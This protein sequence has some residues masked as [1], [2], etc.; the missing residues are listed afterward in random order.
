MAPRALGDEGEGGQKIKRE[1]WLL[2]ASNMTP[3]L[4]KASSSHSRTQSSLRPG[5][6][7]SRW[8]YPSG[9]ALGLPSPLCKSVS[10]EV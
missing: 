4:G 6:G 2:E 5:G 9:A 10:R 7:S 3:E 1:G 8:I